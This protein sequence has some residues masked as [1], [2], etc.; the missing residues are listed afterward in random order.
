[1]GFVVGKVASVLVFIRVRKYSLVSTISPM[2]CAHLAV[3][4]AGTVGPLTN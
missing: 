3:I 1:V 4:Q 2:L